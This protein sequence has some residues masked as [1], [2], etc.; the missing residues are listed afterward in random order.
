MGDESIIKILHDKLKTPEIFKEFKIEN[1]SVYIA[2]TDTTSGPSLGG[3]RWNSYFSEEEAKSDCLNF[4]LGMHYKWIALR[5]LIGDKKLFTGGKAVIND[6]LIFKTIKKDINKNQIID[7]RRLNILFEKFGELVNSING[8]YYTAPDMNTDVDIMSIIKRK[9]DF[10]RC[11]PGETGDPSPTTA[12]GV[13]IGIKELSKQ[14][15]NKEL[16]DLTILIQGAG[17]VG[18]NLINF[19]R[20][21]SEKTKIYITESDKE[22]AKS[23][24]TKFN[25]ILVEEKEIPFKKINIFSPNAKGGTVNKE[26]LKKLNRNTLIA[27][28]A[29]NQIQTNEEEKIITYTPDYYI[30]MGGICNVVFGKEKH[31]QNPAMKLIEG[32]G[33][34]LIKIVQESK[35]K[36]VPTAIIA[37][38]ICDEYHLKELKN[39]RPEVYE[40]LLEN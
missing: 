23:V 17:K 26:L 3:V 5:Q 15:L 24:A 33:K 12:K 36:E 20:Q 19:I 8:K 32:V 30:N 34:L 1:S 29:N 35:I 27:G 7:A 4:S 10:V 22:R 31:R 38:N 2:V 37:N 14:V 16:D 18:S 9:T 6:P 25:C 13:F 40:K 11:L 28:G 21:E 39:K